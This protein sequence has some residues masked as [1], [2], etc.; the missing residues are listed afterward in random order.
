MPASST[1]LI[2]RKDR[3]A[4]KVD[5]VLKEAPYAA[6]AASHEEIVLDLLKERI[7]LAAEQDRMY[8]NYVSNWPVPVENAGRVADLPYVPVAVFKR[9]PP[10][11][12]I[13]E[14]QWQRVLHSSSTTGQQ[15][16]SIVVDAATGRHMTKGVIAILQDFIGSKRRPYL[17]VDSP[18][19]N[20]AGGELGA[21][22]A[23]IRGL[24]PFASTTSYVGKLESDGDRIGLD[25]KKLDE[26]CDQYR[27]EPVLIYGFTF[28]LWRTLVEPLLRDGRSLGLK[29]A[30]VLHSGGWKK[31]TSEAVD[32]ARFIKDVSSAVGCEEDRI[33]DFYGMVENIGV[34]YP[35]CP[36]GL[37]HVTKFGHVIIR[38]PQTLAPVKPGETGIIQVCSALPTS[39]PGHALL[40]E[41]LGE[42]VCEDN[43]EC[44]RGGPGFRFVSRAPK[45]ELRGCGDILGQRFETAAAVAT[46]AAAPAP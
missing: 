4:S 43:C 21:R 39:F 9:D 7:D 46:G 33:I 12:L 15:P 23:A 29:N 34:I 32:K 25:E 13:P 5:A 27:D 45:A 30:H 14:E 16:S 3:I 24:S 17:V 22:G 8:G 35:D 11:A 44:G 41:D 40:T 2:E 31:L 36:Y 1:A 28:V 37:K 20:A 19:S 26:F 42:L 10:F 38:D 6:D 18:E